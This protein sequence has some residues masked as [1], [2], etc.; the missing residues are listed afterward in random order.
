M[1]TWTRG[2]AAALV[3]GVVLTLTVPTAAPATVEERVARLE[4]IT[5]PINA[6]LNTLQWLVGLSVAW[7]TMLIGAAVG[8]LLKYR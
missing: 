4:G 8:I 1:A 3:L 5:E 6:R 7:N 2:L